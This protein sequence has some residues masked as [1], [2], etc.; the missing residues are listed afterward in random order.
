[1]H[2]CPEIS[3]AFSSIE[4]IMRDVDYGWLLRYLHANGA[5]LFFVAVYIH[6][7]RNIYYGSYMQPRNM[8]WNIGV[9]LF[10]LMMGTAFL[11]YVLPWGQMSFWGATVITNFLTAIPYIGQDLVIWVWGGFSVDN[12]TL[13]RFFSLHYLLPFILAVFAILHLVALHEHGSN[14]PTGLASNVDK[15]RFHPYYSSKDFL[16]FLV[17]FWLWAALAFYA[18]D[19]LGHPDNYIPG[20]PLVTP[21]HIVPEWYFLFAYAIL[22]SIPSK[23]WGVIALFASLLILFVLPYLNLSNV[24]SSALKPISKVL[25]WFFIGNFIILTWIGGNP[26][27]EPY[28]WVG[29]WAT[30]F[31]FSYFLILTPTITWLENKLFNL[32]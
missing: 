9:V 26:V 29:Q 5:S 31:Y 22:R 23:F 18:P 13:N 17:W 21:P 8:L 28:V 3:L 14:N 16:G 15:I 12:A 10:I 24:R 4:H 6:I 1:M 7:G 32:S 2:Y 27:E 19:A 25:F 30:I 20:N 11:G